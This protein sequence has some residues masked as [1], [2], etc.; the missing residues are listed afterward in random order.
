MSIDNIHPVLLQSKT[1]LIVSVRRSD[2]PV[3]FYF[4]MD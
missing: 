4:P 1:Q 2:N 3:Y